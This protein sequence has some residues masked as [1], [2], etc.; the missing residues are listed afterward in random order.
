MRVVGADGRGRRPWRIDDGA[1]L[2]RPRRGAAGIDEGVQAR[3]LYSTRIVPETVATGE[4][5][6]RACQSAKAIEL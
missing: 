2:G 6:R 4:Q 5:F 1:R 3:V